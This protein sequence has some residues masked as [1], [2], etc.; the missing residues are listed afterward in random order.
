MRAVD[1]IGAGRAGLFINLVPVFGAGLAV[2]IL[3]ERFQLFHGIG[4]A[5]VITGIALSEIVARRA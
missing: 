5:L 1:L 2:L 3:G 4:L